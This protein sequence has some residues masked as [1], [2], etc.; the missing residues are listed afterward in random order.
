MVLED[1][2][3]RGVENVLFFCVDGLK[4]FPQAVE[5][6]FPK[7]ILQRC[8]VHMVRTSARF[9]SDKDLKKVCADLRKVYTSPNELQAKLALEEFDRKWGK[10]YKYIRPQWGRKLEG[11]DGFYGLY[12]EYTAYDLHDQSGRGFAPGNAKSN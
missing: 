11:I 10:K 4:G 12:T 9:V 7:A 2:K 3:Q 5:G 8:I 6:A 1:L